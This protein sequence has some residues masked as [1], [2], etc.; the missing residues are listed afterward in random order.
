MTNHKTFLLG[1]V[2]GVF[3]L[4]ASAQVKFSAKIAN[5]PTDTIYVKSRGFSQM[6]VADK[7][8]DFKATFKV[9]DGM[10]K[11]EVADQYAE[12]YL[13]NTSDLE[14]NLDYKDFDNTI[15]FKG[16]GAK[17]NMFLA[18]EMLKQ[19]DQSTFEPILKAKN[20]EA[21]KEEVAKFKETIFAKMPQG[22]DAGFVAKYKGDVENGMKE[23]IQ[24]LSGAFELKKLNG[25][26]SPTF[27]YE[28][29]KGGVTSLEDLK[30]KFVY[31]DVWAT[32]CGPCRQ[33]IPFL[34]K[35]EVAYHGK[36]IE[37]V[38]IS[39]DE[40]KNHD[41]WSKFVTEKN[42]GGIQLLADKDWKSDFVKGYKIDGIPRFILISPEGKIVNADA[43]RPSS[44]SLV[45]LLDSLVK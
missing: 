1:V 23:L 15:S 9:T 3:S 32:W 39:I 40:Q 5:K 29:H 7:K 30:G 45:T 8:G 43:P 12:L 11:L 16:E 4:T 18:A 38:S 36:N 35:T 41:K 10:F 22:L 25:T 27:K 2:A 19:P 20:L 24:N 33:E 6:I 13:T 21:L 26:P 42:L 44:P 17:E 34:Q 37:F 31:V 28:N 14:V